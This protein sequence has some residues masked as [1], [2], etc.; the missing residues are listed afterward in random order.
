MKFCFPQPANDYTNF[1]NINLNQLVMKK[2]III[3]ALVALLVTVLTIGGYNYFTKGKEAPVTFQRELDSPVNNVL[4]TMDAEGNTV[5]LDFTQTAKKVAPA[6]VQINV[7][8]SSRSMGRTQQREVRDPFQD[9]FNDD[10]FR[11]MLPR[12]RRQQQ[13]PHERDQDAPVA[14]GKGSGVIIN[15]NGY[16]VTNNHVVENASKV[17]VVMNNHASYI[18]EVIGTDPSSDLAL[19]K[20]DEK[21]LPFVNMV[22]SD[23]VQIGEWVLEVGS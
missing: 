20:I 12:Q 4:Y 11:D 1:R 3:S 16:I 8:I 21:D 18:A 5:P 13:N 9:F 17:E 6:V 15:A 7:E 2:H 10:F 22:N 23:D 14:R 19:I